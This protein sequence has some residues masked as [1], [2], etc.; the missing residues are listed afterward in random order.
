[1]KDTLSLLLQSRFSCRNISIF[2]SGKFADEDLIAKMFNFHR[3]QYYGDIGVSPIVFQAGEF[4]E[5]MAV[6]NADLCS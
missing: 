3:Q 4:N 1:M 5:N 6:W 2:Y